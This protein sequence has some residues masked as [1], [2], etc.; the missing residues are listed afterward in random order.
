MSVEV[1]CQSLR[2]LRDR[3]DV[4]AV[5]AHAER[6]AKAGRAKR[7]AAVE[8][9]GELLGVGVCHELVEPELRRSENL[10]VHAYL[11][12]SARPQARIRS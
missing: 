7:E 5:G 4:H 3:V 2:G 6:A 1:G 8:R 12:F 10:V 9:V 11:P